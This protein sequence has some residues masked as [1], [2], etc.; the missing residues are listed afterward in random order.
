MNEWL[1]TFVLSWIFSEQFVPAS[2]AH[3]AK[4]GMLKRS[5]LGGETHTVEM[6]AGAGALATRLTFADENK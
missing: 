2:A 3:A 6:M 1:K 5:E 4:N